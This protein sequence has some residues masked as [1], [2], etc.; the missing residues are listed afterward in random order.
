MATANYSLPQWNDGEEFKVIAQ[1]NPAFTTI[2][3]EIKNNFSKTAEALSNATSASTAASEAQST[4]DNALSVANSAKTKAEAAVKY[5]K[6]KLIEDESGHG[7]IV[8]LG[9]VANG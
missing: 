7:V 3:K 5:G 4:A 1:L 9:V 6:V 8:T 2:D